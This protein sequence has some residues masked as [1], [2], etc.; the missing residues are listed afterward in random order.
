MQLDAYD[1]RI[2]TE[3]QRDNRLTSASLSEVVHL[4]PAA[5][6]RRVDRL[7]RAGVIIADV[8]VVAPEKVG[9]TL[10][11]VVRVAL[12]TKHAEDLSA[13]EGAARAAPE[14]QQCWH[15]SGGFDY[16]LV[17]SC[18][19][20]ADYDAFLRRFLT[21]NPLV[22][23]YDACISLRRVKTGTTVPLQQPTAETA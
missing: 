12:E 3:L 5:C 15:V 6:L 13:F 11:A 19:D 21:D 7:R 16:V 14:V 18:R 2:L 20:M 1:I 9:V 17:L 22:R 23:N 4:S 10:Q 8:S